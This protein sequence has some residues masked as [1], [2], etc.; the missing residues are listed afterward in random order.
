MKHG[1]AVLFAA[2]SLRPLPAQDSQPG[3]HSAGTALTDFCV[4]KLAGHVRHSAWCRPALEDG[5]ASDSMAVERPAMAAVPDPVLHLVVRRGSAD[6]KWQYHGDTFEISC[7]AKDTAAEVKGQIEEQSGLAADTF[8]LVFNGQ[9]CL[10]SLPPSSF[11]LGYQNAASCKVPK[12]RQDWLQGRRAVPASLRISMFGLL[13][14]VL[15]STKALASYGVIKGAKN[16][17]E[18]VPFSS[19]QS[20]AASTLP[21]TSPLLSSPEHGLVSP[22]A[23]ACVAQ[24]SL[25]LAPAA[26]HGQPACSD[27]AL[28]LTLLTGQP[29]YQLPPV[30]VAG[31]AAG[32]CRHT[33]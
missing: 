25:L 4:M 18:L 12:H 20:S 14:Q 13:L 3:A 15:H 23:H 21:S 5:K 19:S 9:V 30:R 2:L 11:I 17:L 1:P 27:G 28:L 6:I 24:V 7:Q 26:Q 29:H 33:Q 16:L 31:P 32:L 8:K 22:Y 10:S